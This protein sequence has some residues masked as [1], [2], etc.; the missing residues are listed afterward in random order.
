MEMQHANWIA[1]ANAHWKE[2]QPKRYRALMQSGKLGQA[3]TQAASDTSQELQNLRDQGIDPDSAWEMVRQRHLFPPE[4]PGASPEAPP[5][6]GFRTAAAVSRG[7]G[8]LTMP[9]EPKPT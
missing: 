1:Q 6:A 4:E 9:G 2:Y 7:L 5:S 8:S 3:L